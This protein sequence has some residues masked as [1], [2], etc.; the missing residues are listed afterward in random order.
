MTRAIT[1]VVV[2]GGST[3]TPELAD[4]IARLHDT[5]PV[6]RLVLV[7][8][9]LDRTVVVA[10]MCQRILDAADVTAGPIARVHL[11]HRM[12]FGFHANWFASN[13]EAR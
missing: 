1:L 10:S 12:P 6:S 5:L 3:Y 11:P 7:D 13:G 8:P 9:D 2:G 4:G